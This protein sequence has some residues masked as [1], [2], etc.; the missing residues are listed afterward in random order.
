ME[1]GVQKIPSK[2]S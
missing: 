1:A 2:T